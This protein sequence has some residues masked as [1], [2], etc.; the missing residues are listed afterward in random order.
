MDHSVPSLCFTLEKSNTWGRKEKHTPV[1]IVWSVDCLPRAAGSL[2]NVHKH[3]K[4]FSLGEL[5]ERKIEGSN[6]YFC[7]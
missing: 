7:T 4:N 1:F 2:L 5:H 6:L 3:F